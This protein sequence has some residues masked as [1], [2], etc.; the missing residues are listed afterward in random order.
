[1]LFSLFQMTFR[2][3]PN[4][5]TSPSFR[6][7]VLERVWASISSFFQIED[8]PQQRFDSWHLPLIISAFLWFFYLFFIVIRTFC[9]EEVSCN[10]L[11]EAFSS[12]RWL[13][14]MSPGV[15]LIQKTLEVCTSRYDLWNV[16]GLAKWKLS[17][18]VPNLS[19][20]KWWI[21]H[22]KENVCHRQES[23]LHFFPINSNIQY[24]IL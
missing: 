24:F 8:I 12:P 14:W 1:M 9:F 11:S 16:D 15:Q 3:G 7:D 10:P 23:V 2:C 13:Y 21:F 17:L 22:L 20:D 18:K 5:F 6:G 19:M 4:L